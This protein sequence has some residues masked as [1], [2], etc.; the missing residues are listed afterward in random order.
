MGKALIFG[1][2]TEGRKLCESCARAGQPVT[3]CVATEDGM[4]GVSGLANID[5]RVGR[6]EIPEMTELLAEVSLVVDATHPYAQEISK[7]IKCVCSAR[8]LPLLRVARE[9]EAEQGCVYFDAMDDLLGWLEEEPGVIFVSMGS[10]AAAAFQGLANYHERVWMRILPNMNSLRVCLESGYF[11]QRLICMQG[12]FS[13][14]LN[15]AMFKAAGAKILVTKDSGAAG[16]FSE[17]IQAAKSLGMKI[18]VLARP[19]E[20]DGVSLEEAANR[21]IGLRK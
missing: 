12:P 21:L 6:M 2:T 11:P 14:D 4:R 5:I 18:A 7:N 16:G 20:S 19:Q 15:R 10:S 17:K 8:G 3:Y 13:E 1:G 9:R